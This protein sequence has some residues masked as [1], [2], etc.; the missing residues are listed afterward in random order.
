MPAGPEVLHSGPFLPWQPRGPC[1]GVGSYLLLAGSSLEDHS[2]L[3]RAET[4][5]NMIGVGW[6][7]L[8]C[9]SV[10][11]KVSVTFIRAIKLDTRVPCDLISC[12]EGE[13]RA[14]RFSEYGARIPKKVL[15]GLQ[16]DSV[17]NRIL[18]RLRGTSVMRGTVGLRFLSACFDQRR[19]KSSL[20][21]F[22]QF[23]EPMGHIRI[24]EPLAGLGRGTPPPMRSLFLSGKDISLLRG[25]SFPGHQPPSWGVSQ[26]GGQAGVGRG[27]LGCR[28]PPSY[29]LERGPCVKAEPAR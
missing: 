7:Q 25:V 18:G 28:S 22:V 29:H 24:L 26:S 23:L 21:Q 12:L 27:R 11:A 13:G 17:V 1:G 4:N 8:G 15:L 6:T 5:L 3:S 2:S 16:L 14:V 19:R 10:P 9:S 20:V